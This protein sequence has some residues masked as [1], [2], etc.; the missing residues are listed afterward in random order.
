MFGKKNVKKKNM[1]KSFEKLSNEE[2]V[3]IELEMAN[4]KKELKENPEAQEFL[5]TAGSIFGNLEKIMSKSNLNQNDDSSNDRNY[6]YILNDDIKIGS[7]YINPKSEQTYGNVLEKLGKMDYETFEPLPDYVPMEYE[8][9]H[10]P[11]VVAYLF[12]LDGAG[13]TKHGN[14]L[15]IDEKT[16]PTTFK[17][18]ENPNNHLLTY[19]KTRSFFYK[20]LGIDREKD[21]KRVCFINEEVTRDEE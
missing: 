4:L 7:G 14:K 21:N 6:S 12:S 19:E 2:K 18:W 3:K 13:Y 1:E 5:K 17:Q 11:S 10:D 8:F 15:I 9:D 16:N 20:Y